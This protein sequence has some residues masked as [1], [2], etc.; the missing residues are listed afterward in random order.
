VAFNS[1]KLPDTPWHVGYAKKD[2]QD[3]RR[4]K[5]WCIHLDNRICTCKMSGCYL[6]RC[7]GS[8]HCKYYSE[9]ETQWEDFLEE[10]KTEEDIELDAVELAKIEKRKFVRKLLENGSYRYKYS[11]GASM[12]YCPFC[13]TRIK[14]LKCKYCLAKFKVV[15]NYTDEDVAEAGKN[16]YFLVKSI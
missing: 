12:L 6:M 5:A 10:M 2:A 8:S 1:S 16:G 4:H 9:S 11:F 3:P 7:A 15:K 14:G 13:L